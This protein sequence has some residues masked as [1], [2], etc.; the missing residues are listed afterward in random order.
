MLP[1][2]KTFAS[3]LPAADNCWNLSLEGA[4]LTHTPGHR[5]VQCYQQTRFNINFAK[6]LNERKD[7][8]KPEE[9][10]TERAEL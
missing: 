8:F 5:T 2:E 4:K 7:N 3:M 1:L 10:A 6:E 9:T